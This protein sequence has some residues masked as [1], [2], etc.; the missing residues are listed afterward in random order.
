MCRY[1]LLPDW[2]Y[3][4]TSCY[5]QRQQLLSSRVTSAAVTATTAIVIVAATT[6]A[7]FVTLAILAVALLAASVISERVFQVSAP[8]G[9]ALTVA[10]PQALLL[11]YGLTAGFYLMVP[12]IFGTLRQEE[13]GAE[14]AR[15]EAREAPVSAKKEDTNDLDPLFTF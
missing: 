5:Q 3:R 4:P 14:N 6:S 10:L 12:G 9:N 2:R 7:P 1:F 11:A 13:G 8:D 15:Q